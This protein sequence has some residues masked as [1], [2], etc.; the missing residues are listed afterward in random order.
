MGAIW[1]ILSEEVIF[2]ER[3]EWSRE[4][5]HTEMWRKGNPGIENTKHTVSRNWSATFII[6]QGAQYGW[7]MEIG[8]EQSSLRWVRISISGHCRLMEGF[9]SYNWNE[10]PLSV[11]VWDSAY[12][13]EENPAWCFTGLNE[14]CKQKNEESGWLLNFCFLQWVNVG[15]ISWEDG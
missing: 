5:S 13:L 6:N 12:I 3:P 14:G 10:N 7:S 4:T 2:E 9:G 11:K 15:A 1:K 8:E